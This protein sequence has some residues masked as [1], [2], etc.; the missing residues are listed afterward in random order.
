MLGERLSV[1]LWISVALDAV[2]DEKAVRA[3][4]GVKLDV[5]R[6]DAPDRRQHALLV[7]DAGRR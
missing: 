4:R 6:K 5:Q 1:I 3:R 2:L 7:L